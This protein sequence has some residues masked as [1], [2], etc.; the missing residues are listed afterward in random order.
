LPNKASQILFNFYGNIIT[1]AIVSRRY[2]Y[3]EATYLEHFNYTAL[4]GSTLSTYENS[5]GT[6]DILGSVQLNTR[7]QKI[8]TSLMANL[9]VS[10]SQR[11]FFQGDDKLYSRDLTPSFHMM[12]RFRPTKNLSGLISSDITYL[13]SK[14]SLGEMLTQA[15]NS[16]FRTTLTYNVGK[17]L[18]I[19]SRYGISNH[20]FLYGNL[21]AVTHHNLSACVGAKFMQ[22]RLKLTLS[23]N[24][25]LN[26]G[27]SYSIAT[28]DDHTVQTWNPTYG[29]FYLFT[30]SFRLNK[31]QSKTKFQGNTTINGEVSRPDLSKI[32]TMY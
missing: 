23:G 26:S 31:L 1:D 32:P 13:Q 15:V 7:I 11:P 2:Y 8:G 24:D 10:Y 25:L 27:A 14:N 19:G 16:S 18:Y 6:W 29:R 28:K 21:P 17:H 3:S 22:G 4:P 20:T 5:N 9:G 12:A 30:V